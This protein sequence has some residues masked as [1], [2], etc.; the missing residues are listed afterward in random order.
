M[1]STNLILNILCSYSSLLTL[2]KVLMSLGQKN[3]GH[4]SYR[5]SK[6]TRILKSSL[7]GNARMAVICCITPS[8]KYIEETRSTLQFATRAKLVKTNALKNEEQVQD[9]DLIAKYR[10]EA[11]KAKWENKKLE[12]RL[13][14]VEDVNSNALTTERELTNLK[15]FMFSEK[16]KT[17]MSNTKVSK[18]QPKRLR[19]STASFDDE[20]VVATTSPLVKL[21][22]VKYLSKDDTYVHRTRT[23]DDDNS[24][25]EENTLLRTALEEKAKQVRQLMTEEKKVLTAREKRMSLITED[26]NKDRR[27][28]LRLSLIGAVQSTSTDDDEK[29]INANNLIESLESQIDELIQQKNEAL[30]WIEDLFVKEDHTDEKLKQLSKE[31]D[32]AVKNCSELDN[33]L[34]KHEKLL[35]NASSEIEELRSEA[36]DTSNSKVEELQLELETVKEKYEVSQDSLR[37]VQIE[38]RQLLHDKR[39]VDFKVD[40]LEAE[41]KY[42]SRGTKAPD[43][44]A[45]SELGLIKE[46]KVKVHELE[47]MTSEYNQEKMALVDQ[48]EVYEQELNQADGLL[49]EKSDELEDALFSL[50]KERR[51]WLNERNE[52]IDKIQSMSNLLSL[53]EEELKANASNNDQTSEIAELKFDNER[54]AN[55]C[56]ESM[57]KIDTLSDELNETRR[58]RDNAKLA[59]REVDDLRVERSRLLAERQQYTKDVDDCCSRMEDLSNELSRLQRE[60]QDSKG[61]EDKMHQ[62]CAVLDK[63]NREL[64]ESLNVANAKV[65]ELFGKYTLEEKSKA[66]LRSSVNRIQELVDELS[67]ENAELKEKDGLLERESRELQHLLTTTTTERDDLIK[68]NKSLSSKFKDVCLE[69]DLAIREKEIVST[70]LVTIAADFEADYETV[71]S[72]VDILLDEKQELQDKVTFLQ[73]SK[74]S[75]EDNADRILKHDNGL[76]IRHDRLKTEFKTQSIKMSE[77]EDEVKQIIK[78]LRGI[79]SINEHLSNDNRELRNDIRARVA[80]EPRANSGDGNNKRRVIFGLRI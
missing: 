42:S 16:S 44:I 35:A 60:L 26:R 72:K 39:T 24:L 47:D 8:S 12:D 69:R 62:R 75:I 76:G 70:K 77:L 25:S 49:K 40:E 45:A 80:A 13:R 22:S 14:K 2:S 61:R 29:L 59:S 53:K 20:Q 46:L 18:V 71:R 33:E 74:T 57:Q 65:K 5:D 11:A 78:R 27:E 63:E 51:S 37:Q 64:A 58:Q 30:D 10:L 4:I 79:K 54:L 43:D 32:D 31:K 50:D 68:S 28:S 36:K 66:Q 7:S 23:D 1:L 9:G 56:N 67:A 52:H 3:P 15:K 73:A 6:L 55:E 34:L 21:E 41:L 17:V 48:I 38:N 19:F